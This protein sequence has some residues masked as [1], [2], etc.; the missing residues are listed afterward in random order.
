M[1]CT[2]VST[3]K[4]FDK[5]SVLVYIGQL[6]SVFTIASKHLKRIWGRHTAVNKPHKSSEH[7][8]HREIWEWFQIPTVHW[9]WDDGASSRT[10]LRHKGFQGDKGRSS[11]LFAHSLPVP[12]PRYVNVD[13]ILCKKK[14]DSLF[15]GSHNHKIF[16]FQVTV[17]VYHVNLTFSH[18]SIISFS[19]SAP[20]SPLLSTTVAVGFVYQYCGTVTVSNRQRETVTWVTIAFSKQ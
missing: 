10:W 6:F 13:I 9:W 7:C 11:Q 2:G 12:I 15:V 16:F 18:V 20:P 1:S 14:K 3:S 8:M 17:C 5:S 4:R 19:F